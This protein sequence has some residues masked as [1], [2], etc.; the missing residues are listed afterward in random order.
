MKYV[1]TNS[2]MLR[3]KKKKKLSKLRVFF[4]FFQKLNFNCDLGKL[5]SKSLRFGFGR[6][7]SV[8]PVLESLMHPVFHRE[9]GVAEEFRDSD[10]GAERQE[11][12]RDHSVAGF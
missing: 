1:R 5:Q 7:P 3:R 12:C 8:E 6:E 11:V 4:F 9:Y 2:R 10:L